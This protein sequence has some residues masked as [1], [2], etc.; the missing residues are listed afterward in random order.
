[1]FSIFSRSYS[2]PH[3]NFVHLDPL[4]DRL[5]VTHFIEL[6]QPW[7]LKALPAQNLRL[8]PVGKDFLQLVVHVL[9]RWDGE[10]IIEFYISSQSVLMDCDIRLV[11]GKSDVT[12]P[13]EISAW[14]LATTRISL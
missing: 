7:R 10:D 2:P 1:M 9:A 3:S 8:D 11:V 5:I 4:P 13:R 14:S 6:V 12:Y